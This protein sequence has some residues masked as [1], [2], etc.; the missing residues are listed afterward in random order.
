MVPDLRIL[1]L[2]DDPL[3][4]A[5]LAALLAGQ[6]GCVIA[7][8]AASSDDLLEAIQAHQPDLLLWDLGWDPAPTLERMADPASSV[9]QTL[10]AVREPL[11]VLLADETHVAEAW[12]AGGRGAPLS[13]GRDRF[14]V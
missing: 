13:C 12:S 3:A 7:G 10:E 14:R 9:G 6:P 1:I 8:Q 2:A 11:V 5:G 4:R